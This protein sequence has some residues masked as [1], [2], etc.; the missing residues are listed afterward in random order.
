MILKFDDLF[1]SYS[2]SLP[3]ATIH[4]HKKKLLPTLCMLVRYSSQFAVFSLEDL[5]ARLADFVMHPYLG[6]VL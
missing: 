4:K 1:D 2:S 6:L 5:N 3:N